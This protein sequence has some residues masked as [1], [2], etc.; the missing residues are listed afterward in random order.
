M[1]LAPGKFNTYFPDKS[2]D[3]DT[4]ENLLT[5]L[6][7]KYQASALDEDEMRDAVK[8]TVQSYS[9]N[10]ASAIKILGRF[11]EFV[12][13]EHGFDAKVSFPVVD[14]SSSFE[15]QMYLAKVF[16]E[17]DATVTSVS[18]ELWVS[19]RTVEKDL[20]RLRGNT[21]D[22]IQVCG[23]PFIINETQR[24]NKRLSFAS[25]VHPFFLTFNLTQ[26]IT[27]LKGLKMM[28]EEPALKH[29]AR[30][31]AV[32][33]WEQLSPYAQDRILFVT[34]NLIPDELSWYES[35]DQEK[36]VMFRTEYEYRTTDGPGV[37]MDCMKNEKTC[38]VEYHQED[39]SMQFF[40]NCSFVPRS[41]RDGKVDV[42]C[43]QGKWSLSLNRILRSAYTREGLF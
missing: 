9:S 16:Q 40:S 41:Y 42:R 27:T 29:Y 25:T 14:I 33:L 24:H 13:K 17:S 7:E 11:L 8:A 30:G 10:K 32:S 3:Q 2:F 23:K 19:E 1:F 21:D 20:A 4:V 39:G 5:L 12:K 37:L 28:C 43:D 18:E 36:E 34:G 26:V 38:F 31:S 15:R 35:L 6:G 22:P